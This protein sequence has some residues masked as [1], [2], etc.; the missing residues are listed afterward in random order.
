MCAPL[1]HLDGNPELLC[2]TSAARQLLHE[3]SVHDQRRTLTDTVLID[4]VCG[5]FGKRKRVGY[6]LPPIAIG[7]V[8]REFKGHGLRGHEVIGEEAVD[9][10][11]DHNDQRV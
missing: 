10:V 3:L 7:W 6:V 11:F 9:G 5:I 4:L 8:C 2:Y 1:H